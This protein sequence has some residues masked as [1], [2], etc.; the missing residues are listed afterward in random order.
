[1]GALDLTKGPVVL[2]T[3]PGFGIG[4]QYLL[5]VTDA[6]KNH[7]DGAKTYRVTLPKGIPQA[8]SGRSRRFAD[9]DFN[10]CG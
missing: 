6:E 7:V 3:A 9:E 5:A 1:M 8:I 2:E 10:L 4:S